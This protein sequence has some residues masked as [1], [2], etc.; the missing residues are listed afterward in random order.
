MCP[1]TQNLNGLCVFDCVPCAGE[2]KTNEKQEIQVFFKPDHESRHFSDAAR[3]ILFNSVS[4]VQCSCVRCLM[5]RLWQN[6]PVFCI[7]W[8]ICEKIKGKQKN[9]FFCLESAHL[10]ST[11][12]LI[13]EKYTVQNLSKRSWSELSSFEF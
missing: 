6:P 3:F 11:V 4:I 10:A 12:F 13:Y 7:N 8:H 1:G 5:R 2:L 9:S